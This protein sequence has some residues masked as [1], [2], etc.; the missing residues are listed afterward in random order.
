MRAY[1]NAAGSQPDV[2]YRMFARDARMRLHTEESFEKL[3]FSGV[4]EVM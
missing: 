4:N 1:D 3:R 2:Q